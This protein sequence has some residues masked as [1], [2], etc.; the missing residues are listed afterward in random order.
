MKTTINHPTCS[1]CGTHVH[2]TC[3]ILECD[4]C[5]SKTEED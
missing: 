3:Y 4:R 5:L 2:E 1:V